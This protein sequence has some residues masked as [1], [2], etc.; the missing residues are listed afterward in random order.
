MVTPLRHFTQLQS[1]HTE[2]T[3]S[4]LLNSNNQTA[5]TGKADVVVTGAGILGLTFRPDLKIEVFEKSLAPIQKIGESALS[6]F[7]TFT[8]GDVL[9]YNYLLRL[10]G[11]KDGIQ[12]YNIDQDDREVTA[13]DVGGLDVSFQLDRRM[14]ELFM[15][16]WAQSLGVNVYHVC[17][18]SGFSRHLTSKFGAREKFDSGWNTDAYWTY[19]HEKYTSNIDGRLLAWN[20]P[21]TKHICFPEGWGWFIGLISWHHA[22]LTNLMDLVAHVIASAAAGIPAEEF[23]CTRELSDTFTYD[24]SAYGAGEAEQK[25]N[26]FRKR[27]PVIDTLLTDSFELLPGYYGGRTYFV[28]KGLAYRS[29]VVAGEG[30]L[31][32]GNSAGFTN[33]LIS[34]GINVGIGGAW[35]AAN[36]TAEVLATPVEE[37]RNAMIAAAKSHQTFI[38]DFVLPRLDNMNR[39]WYN[40]FRDHRLFEALPRTLWALGHRTVTLCSEVLDVLD[41]VNGGARPSEEQVQKALVIIERTVWKRTE[42]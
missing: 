19:F 15:T 7:S 18:V 6:P 42:I 8:D 30:W 27:Y 31:A 33:P 11:L 3:E 16:M 28:R 20:Y 23:S 22:P 12:L 39:T 38:H 1:Q 35:R 24:L 29:P 34:P 25:F 13:H 4:Q 14:S 17:D 36:L 37:A 21:A 32:I 41:G 26:F 10:F 5:F 9:P 2:L 40:S